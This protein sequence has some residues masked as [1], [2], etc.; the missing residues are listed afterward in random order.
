MT[1]TVVINK[2]LSHSATENYCATLAQPR[3]NLKLHFLFQCLYSSN[4]SISVYDSSDC[5]LLT[6]FNS[7]TCNI[8]VYSVEILQDWLLGACVVY[9]QCS[10]GVLVNRKCLFN[11]NKSGWFILKRIDSTRNSSTEILYKY[12]KSRSCM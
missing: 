7:S 9:T 8:Y 3:K 6:H 2:P 10:I 12:F 1:V 5:L 4:C 11:L